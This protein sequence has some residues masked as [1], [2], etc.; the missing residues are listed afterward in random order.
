MKWTFKLPIPWVPI[1]LLLLLVLL[2]PHV[3]A[4]N[5]KSGAE[6]PAIGW[7]NKTITLVVPV[8]AG[9][10]ADSTA[11]VLADRLT[12]L[13]KTR[14]VVENRA[15]AE[16]LVGIS[17][18]AA[19]P[20]DGYTWLF[21]FPSVIH[22]RMT[23]K[24]D[25][26]PLKALVPVAKITDAPLILLVRSNLANT[27]SEF[28]QKGKQTRTEFNCAGSGAN[29]T[30]ACQMLRGMGQVP[31][32]VVTYKGNAAAA[33]DLL[34]GHVDMMFDL[35]NAAQAHASNSAVRALA[36]TGSRR[37]EPPF[38]DLPTTKDAVPGFVIDT[39]QGVM[40]PAGTP[41]VIRRQFEQAIQE[42]LG[43]V[44]LRQRINKMGLSIDF[45]NS[46]QFSATLQNEVKK[47]Q[48]LTDALGLFQK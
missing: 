7:P 10:A 23:H 12:E 22:L 21:A 4:Q 5:S 15:G 39:W 37:A 2:V 33:Q 17:H 40:A 6:T 36:S 45:E 26:D 9:G 13:L 29:P 38:A 16:S 18:V 31:L 30:L 44:V 46:S 41:E 34:G 27:W 14:V 25:F 47:Y 20:A 48:K 1:G 24:L 35:P 8:P 3:S 43:D 28:L 19:A 42:A 11:R 32:Q